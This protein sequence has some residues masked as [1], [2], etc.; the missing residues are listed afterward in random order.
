MSRV[1]IPTEYYAATF[2]SQRIAGIEQRFFIRHFER[3]PTVV[4]GAVRNIGR[5][6][7]KI[8]IIRQDGSPLAVEFLQPK[9]YLHTQR[10]SAGVEGDPAVALALRR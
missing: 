8:I 10:F 2:G 4:A 9:T 5:Q 1:Y 7:D 6:Q 3:D